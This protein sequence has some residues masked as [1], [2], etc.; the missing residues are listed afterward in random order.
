VNIFEHLTARDFARKLRDVADDADTERREGGMMPGGDDLP[1][2]LRAA[3]DRI[4]PP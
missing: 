1:D 2:L 3:A 4:D